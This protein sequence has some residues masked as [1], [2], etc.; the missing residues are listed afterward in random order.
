M[1]ASRLVRRGLAAA[2][3][4]FCCSFARPEAPEVVPQLASDVDLRS[5]VFLGGRPP[6]P[7]LALVLS[8]GGARGAAHAGVLKVFEELHIVPDLI[9]GTSMGSI[10][11]GLY[12]AGYSP[13]EIEQILETTDWGEAMVDRIRREERSYRRKK[14]DDILLFPLKLRFRGLKPYLPTGLLGGQRLELLLRSLVMNATD[15]RDF[16]ALP[17]PYRAVAA[18]IRTGEAVVLGEGSL[19]DAMRASMSIA[20]TFPPVVWDGR[21]LV[22][23]GAVA[24]VPVG[25]AQFLGAE[26]VLVV[27]ISSPL[28]ENVEQA[29]FLGIMG[30]LSGLLT[31]GNRAVDLARLREGDLL[32]RPDLRDVTFTSFKKVKEAVDYGEEAAR[33]KIEELR[34]FAA[35]PERWAAFEERHRRRDL[36]SIP[37]QEVRLENASWVDDRIVLRNLDV[38]LGEP[39]DVDRL[40]SRLIETYGLEY[41]GIIRDDLRAKDGQG[42]L[43]VATPAK[44]Y[45]RGSLQFGLSFESDLQ[46]DASYAFTVRHQ[47]LAVNRRAGEWVNV[48]QLGGDIVATSEFYQPLDWGMRWFAAP[49]VLYESLQQKIWVDEQ[50]VAEYDLSVGEVR[51]DI[52]RVFGNWGEIRLGTFRGQGSASPGIGLAIFPSLELDDGGLALRFSVDT[53]DTVTFPTRGLRGRLA[54]ERSLESFGADANGTSLGLAVETALTS[55]RNTFLLGAEAADFA[56]DT[57]GPGGGIALGGFLRL[58][59]LGLNELL[60]ER[61]VLARAVYYREIASLNLGSLENRIFAGASLE[62]GNTY[63]GDDPVT[64]PSLRVGGAIFIGAE[65]VIGPAY[66]GWGWTDPNRNHWYFVF[67]RR[68]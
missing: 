18:D 64:W 34:G 46:G 15:A 35:P 28:D 44:P 57:A 6:A 1:Q 32:I 60:G 56:G 54:V 66:L 53:N 27:D 23:G 49:S 24:N 41:F 33:A 19:A 25:I 50:P 11:G 39:L 42:F 8:G 61:G 16:D 48:L 30:Q 36:A 26:R 63:N 3:V 45:S 47:V 52:G 17:I 14:D 21:P 68:F 38:P 31:V 67:G 7:H 10:V 59:G 2:C 13:A 55:G 12:A 40:R 62:A 58:S 51:L 9:V 29:S 65:T 20:G 5:A 37:V 22:D 43:T 4:L